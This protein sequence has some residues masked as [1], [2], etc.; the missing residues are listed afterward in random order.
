MT[1]DGKPTGNQ[2]KSTSADP[3]K[4]KAS[5]R[6]RGSIRNALEEEKRQKLE[7]M[8]VVEFLEA[9]PR[10]ELSSLMESV[11]DLI[12][13]ETREIQ[14]QRLREEQTLTEL[15]SI[16]RALQ[17]QSLRP[18][19]LARK[20]EELEKRLVRYRTGA[21]GRPGSSHLVVQEFLRRIKARDLEPTVRGQAVALV[22]WLRDSHPGAVPVTAKTVENA[23]RAAYRKVAK[24]NPQNY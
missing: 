18:Q 9:Q 12:G 17:E 1:R 23:I 6:V 4:K 19:E 15:R 24:A 5:G 20:A 11:S 2:R 16:R 3:A 13:E 21:P 10:S 14:D 7:G 8:T 22:E